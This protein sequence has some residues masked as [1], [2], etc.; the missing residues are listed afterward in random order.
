[1]SGGRRQSGFTLTELMVVVALV[2]LLATLA[3][4][5]FR[6]DPRPSDVASAAASLFREASRRAVSGGAVR[7]DVVANLGTR[8]RSRLHLFRDESDIVLAVEVLEEAPLPSNDASWLERSRSTVPRGTRVTG[9]RPVADL[10][11]GIGP[12][13]ALAPE[14]EVEVRCY[15][16]GTC[17]AA[18]LYF[19]AITGIRKARTVLMPLGGSPA[20]FAS[21]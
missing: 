12:G 19:E 5:S 13:I 18:T 8:A 11:G 9:W 15:P 17:D 16:T 20:T 6:A 1:V 7:G 10:A 21:W 14:D 4:G 2:A 3:W